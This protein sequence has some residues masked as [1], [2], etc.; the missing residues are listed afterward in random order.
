MAQNTNIN[1]FANSVSITSSVRVVHSKAKEDRINA[2][3][4]IL[5]GRIIGA[6][7]YRNVNYVKITNVI[8]TL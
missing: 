1:L 5:F 8:T 6:V 3:N 7:S 4:P 2:S